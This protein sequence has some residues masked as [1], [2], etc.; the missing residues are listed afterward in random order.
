MAGTIKQK[1]LSEK[2]I[3]VCNTDFPTPQMVEFVGD[4][5]FDALF[6]DCEQSSTDFK[7]VEELSRAAR[8]SNM[9]SV[10]RPYSKEPGLI[11]RYLSCGAGG[12]QA[13]KVGSVEEGR[14]LL[15]GMSHWDKGD[16]RDKIIIFMIESRQGIECLPELLKL[17]EVDVFYFGQNDLAESMGLKGD[18]KNPKVRSLVEDGIRRTADAGKIA[19]MNVQDEIDAV[20]HYMD[21]GLRWVNVH[22]KQFMAR[23]SK[24]FI[25][26]AKSRAAG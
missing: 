6:I 26:A 25:S 11:N 16:Y 22:Q 7:L 18:R 12:I 23:G 4:L 2:I 8:V 9:A 21:L 20:G 5:G 24:A 3:T 17:E 19:G 14:A 10:L 1:V 15:D 13:P